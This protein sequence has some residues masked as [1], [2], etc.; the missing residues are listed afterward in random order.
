MFNVLATAESDITEYGI[1]YSTTKNTLEDL[2]SDDDV[3]AEKAG[4]STTN[5]LFNMAAS[6]DITYYVTVLTFPK[7]VP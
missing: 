4:S 1:R 3:T 6:G 7:P 5:W 2:K